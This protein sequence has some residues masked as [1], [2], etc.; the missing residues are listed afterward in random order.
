MIYTIT[1]NPSLDLLVQVDNLNEGGVNYSHSDSMTASGR[2]INISQI[3]KTMSVPTMAT[4]LVGGKTGAFIEDELTKSNIPYEFIHIEGNTRINLSIFDQTVE[5]R[6]LGKGPEVSMN[7]INELLF[8]LARIREGD[9][10]I[11]AGSLP[12]NAQPSLYSRIVELSVVNRAQIIPVLP[13]EFLLETLKDKPLVIVPTLE[14]LSDMF[15]ESILD[16]KSAL[17]FALRCIEEGAQNVIVNFQREGSLLVTSDRKVY[18]APG[19][20]GSIVSSTYTQIASVAGFVGQ[21]MQSGDAIES[22]KVAQAATNA[23][24]LVKG[25]PTHEDL[26]REED[27]IEILPVS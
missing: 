25:L 17:P 7:E 21:Y 3:L 14:E 6:I 27:K 26:R 11:L 1:L 18:E 9:M 10:V 24:Y 22:Y 20:E 16:K 13:P 19:P 5:T 8:F 12:P 23:T 4:G 15:H 2:A